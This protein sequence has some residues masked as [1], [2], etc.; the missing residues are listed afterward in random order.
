MVYSHAV[1]DTMIGGREKDLL[2]NSFPRVIVI[3]RVRLG[4]NHG[5]GSACEVG[6]RR[7]TETN[8]RAELTAAVSS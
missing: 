7:R 6:R 5:G 2:A 3:L 1:A 8:F 4:R